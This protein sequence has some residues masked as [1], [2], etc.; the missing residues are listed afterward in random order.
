MRK[1]ILARSSLG[2]LTNPGS[3]MKQQSQSYLSLYFSLKG[4]RTMLDDILSRLQNPES[5]IPEA[6]SLVDI[7]SRLSNCTYG[8]LL[9]TTTDIL[10]A[11]HI[12]NHSPPNP[13]IHALSRRS[14]AIST[15]LLKQLS[16]LQVGNPT[17]PAFTTSL[18]MP[19]FSLPDDN[20]PGE[21]VICRI[22]DEQ[23]PLS[24]LE[25]HTQSCLTAYRSQGR[26]SA[27]SQS[28]NSLY[29]RIQATPLNL[30][31]PAAQYDATDVILPML[32]LHLLL[33]HA[34]CIEPEL[35][36]GP[37][38]LSDICDQIASFPLSESND[39]LS[40]IRRLVSEKKR[41]SYALRGA[42]TVLSQTRVSGNDNT[43]VEVSIADFELVKRISAGA[44][45][46][47]FLARKKVTNDIYA[48]KVIP[49]SGLIRKN[50]LKRV[51]AERDILLRANNDFI[52]RCYYSII[53]KS[54]LYLLMEYLP[55][56][57]LY[58]ILQNLG[59]LDET[60]AQIYAV[61]IANALAH[62]HS[63]GIIHRD[64]KPDNILISKTGDLKLTDFGL[65][66]IGV[67]DREY[68]DAADAG[69]VATSSSCLGTPDYIAPEIL[70]LQNHTYTVDWWSFGVIVYEFLAGIPP[71]H[72]PTEQETHLNAMKGQYEKLSEDDFSAEAVD[73]VSRLLLV[74]PAQRLGAGGAAEVLQHPWLCGV[75]IVPPFIPELRDAEDTGYFTER[76]TPSSTDDRDILDDIQACRRKN[77]L[78]K[79]G[80]AVFRPVPHFEIQSFAPSAAEGEGEGEGDRASE[81]KEFSGV[82]ADSLS[83][84]NV[85]MT[86]RTRTRRSTLEHAPKR[87]LEPV[88]DSPLTRKVCSDG[89]DAEAKEQSAPARPRSRWS[90]DDSSIQPKRRRNGH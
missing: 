44:F 20:G 82:S 28:L 73:F 47:V 45:A 27:V 8:T 41:I 23:V 48:M 64:L 38:E 6:Q 40:D 57:D 42:A 3:I 84:V 70:L 46:R 86:A 26:L 35:E 18:S 87:G 53:G 51:L 56:G 54:N 2:S 52:T 9:Q 71:F 89:S 50:Q 36:N 4:Q 65:S 37:S 77:P 14:K 24:S 79:A 55:G 12:L 74:D 16:L 49:K 5:P 88:G 75:D 30:A 85:A 22:C 43:K 39:Y 90:I 32:H 68:G 10:P 61:Q 76:Y 31:W 81:F 67:V 11:L 78:A 58:S 29:S 13:E 66:Y 21:S 1:G 63:H 25:E 7:V 19:T 72:A 69:E 34:I 15:A 59:A 17:Q 60:S 80:S 33:G 62:L 83:L